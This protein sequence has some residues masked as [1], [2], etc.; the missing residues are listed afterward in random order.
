VRTVLSKEPFD[1]VALDRA[2]EN[3]RAR[4]IALQTEI[5]MTIGEAAAS[6]PPDARQKLA[7]WRAES[8]GR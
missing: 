3:V 8:R 4:N 5:Q 6:L 2:F 1:R 7:N